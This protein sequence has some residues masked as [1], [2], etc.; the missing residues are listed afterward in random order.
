MVHGLGHPGQ[1]ISG[2]RIAV[3]FI[4]EFVARLRVDVHVQVLAAGIA[5]CIGQAGETLAF[6]DRITFAAHHQ[7]WQARINLFEIGRFADL[8]Q[9]TQQVDP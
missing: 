6:T 5:Q 1:H 2:D 9:A 7:D 8:L 3:G 4:E